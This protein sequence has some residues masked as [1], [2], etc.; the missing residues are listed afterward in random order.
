MSLE[1]DV[2]STHSTKESR[3][4]S[5][6]ILKMLPDRIVTYAEKMDSWSKKNIENSSLENLKNNKVKG[7]ISD[8]SLRLIKKHLHAWLFAV[9]YYNKTHS[10]RQFE[11]HITMITLTLSSPQLE[12]HSDLE[13][14]RRL[15]GR[16]IEIMRK[17]HSIKH[18]FVRYESQENGNIHAHLLIDRFIGKKVLQDTWNTVQNRLGYIDRF[19]DKHGHRN[20][21]STHVKDVTTNKNILEYTLK[22]ALKEEKHREITGRLY[23]MSDTLR[24]VESQTHVI[25]SDVSIFLYNC[26]RHEKARVYEGDY[27]TIIFL[28]SDYYT[29][30]L[31]P[32]LKRK[33]EKYYLSV[34]NYLYHPRKEFD[35]SILT[36]QAREKY[37]NETKQKASRLEDVPNITITQVIQRSLFPMPEKTAQQTETDFYNYR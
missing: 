15:F 12:E 34:Y 37:E 16:F 30:M 17:K 6:P 25:D 4:T 7:K 13:I 21:P 8:R 26:R 2:H 32:Q 1:N 20:P 29:E 23:G 10:Q 28:D 27:F 14:K 35:T 19:E 3:Y 5:I 22:Y 9:H 24:D 18:Y 36:I 33:I 11:R 31:S